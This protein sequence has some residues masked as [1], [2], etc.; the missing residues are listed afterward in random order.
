MRAD[1]TI[2]QKMTIPSLAR[3]QCVSAEKRQNSAFGCITKSSQPNLHGRK[4]RKEA[5]ITPDSAVQQ[6]RV[7]HVVS[8]EPSIAH[9]S[10]SFPSRRTRSTSQDPTSQTERTALHM[11]ARTTTISPFRGLFFDIGPMRK[12]GTKMTPCFD[13]ERGVRSSTGPRFTRSAR[14]PFYVRKGLN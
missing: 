5:L 12:S 2:E 6:I 8:C 13:M 4:R 11:W 3:V 1:S 9:Q 7:N 14:R 10:S